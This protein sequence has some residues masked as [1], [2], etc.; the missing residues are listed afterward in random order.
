MRH[1]RQVELLKRLQGFDRRQPAPVAPASMRN[2]AA[3]YTD[4]GRYQTERERLFRRRPV[5]VGLSG[6]LAAPGD[7]LTAEPGGVPIV[8]LRAQDGALRGFV[9]ACRHRAAPRCAGKRRS[10]GEADHKKG[11]T[12]ATGRDSCSK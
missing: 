11:S 4:P 7:Y 3:A 2:P 10:C 9:N 1:E 6:D 12:C 5:L 8:V